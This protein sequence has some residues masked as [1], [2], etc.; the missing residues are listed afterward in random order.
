MASERDVLGFVGDCGRIRAELAELGAAPSTICRT[1]DA[2]K[3]RF[4]LNLERKPKS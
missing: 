4:E 2:V 3:G 1:R